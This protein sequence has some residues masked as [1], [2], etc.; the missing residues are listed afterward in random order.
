MRNNLR[1]ELK[2][3]EYALQDFL[4]VKA[5]LDRRKAG[6]LKEFLFSQGRDG[7]A[8]SAVEGLHL[9]RQLVLIKEG[10]PHALRHL[11]FVTPYDGKFKVRQLSK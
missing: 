2:D 4:E 3:L 5:S 10:D 1:E 7:M 8:L 11:I 9:A 6:P